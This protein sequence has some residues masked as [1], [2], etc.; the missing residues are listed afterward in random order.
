MDTAFYK[1]YQKIMFSD[2][3]S[4]KKGSCDMCLIQAEDEQMK[5]RRQLAARLDVAVH[6]RTI[7]Y[8]ET[9]SQDMYGHA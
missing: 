9:D 7:P 3:L 5:D 1:K 8:W 6:M 4:I 2:L